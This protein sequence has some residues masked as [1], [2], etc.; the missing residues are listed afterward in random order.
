MW[1]HLKRL[2]LILKYEDFHLEAYGFFLI[3]I[4]LFHPVFFIVGI[5][6]LWLMRK[7]IKWPLLWL[8]TALLLT[9]FYVTQH[10]E[11]M[12]HVQ[13]EVKISSIQKGTYQDQLTVRY[14]YRKYVMYVPKDQYTLQ[15]V[16]YVKGD[17]KPIKHQTVP[18]GFDSKTYYVSQGVFG[19][20]DYTEIRKTTTTFSLLSYRATLMDHL[21]DHESTT[22]MK[23]LLF[24]EKA[25]SLEQKSL[26]QGLNL[27]YLLT[28]SGF[29]V[30][31]LIVWIKKIM[32]YLSL[33][34]RTQHIILIVFYL[35]LLYMN[36]FSLG[37]LRLFIMFIWMRINQKYALKLTKLDMIQLTFFV[38]LIT[39][40]FFL[41][42]L[43][44]LMTYLILNGIHLMEIRYR[45]LRGY[46]KK[47]SIST[48]ILL[49]LLPINQKISI[50]TLSLLPWIMSYVSYLLYPMT[51]LVFGFPFL[52]P[53]LNLLI[54]QFEW[55][56]KLISVKEISFWIPKFAAWQSLIYFFLI[57]LM[58][59][60]RDKRHWILRTQWVLFF[61]IGMTFFSIRQDKIV[62]L[63]VGQG[64]GSVITSSG[65]VTV[66]DSFQH[67]ALYLRDKGHTTIDYLVLTH[68]HL[69]H[70][71]EA[72]SLIHTF[73]VRHLVL[74]KYDTYEISHSKK[75]LHL[76]SGD[77]F[78]CGHVTFNVL[79]PMRSYANTN[80]NSLVIQANFHQLTFLWTGDIEKEA[81]MDLINTYRDHLKSD[82]LKV[83]HHGSS[84]SSTES[85]IAYV[86]PK[87]AVIS[88]QE[89]NRH[90]FPHPEV[91][92]RLEKHH[93]HIY[94][95]DFHGSILFDPKSRR[96][97]W[98]TMLPF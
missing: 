95:T 86:S 27:M 98:K 88:V 44:F 45:P 90:R 73:D 15:D 70:T 54:E 69:D 37:V 63:D 87:I 79:G 7:R 31:T 28:V 43:G 57:I 91:I 59:R 1:S 55:F 17:I 26:Y 92:E 67:V 77:S 96:Q 5:P 13:A 84:T 62:F 36:A 60:S 89:G 3:A 65:C 93:V 34:E 18:G 48:I 82:V 25:F 75:T 10:H 21:D 94:R 8:A 72:E 41:Y 68:N 16:I 22:Y 33:N 49:I 38:L 39:H 76:M 56:L 85:F 46:L 50:L 19:L 2:S 51:W 24:G 97:K 83:S 52:T 61:I 14:Q 71:K 74:S 29:H 42:H 40:P 66:I 80:D 53:I 35:I 4:S 64:D 78:T 32:F 12:Q 9:F 30:Y 6:Y 23:S 11:P 58:F 81:E 20:I 47:L